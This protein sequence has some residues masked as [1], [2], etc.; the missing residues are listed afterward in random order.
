MSL[1]NLA[2]ARPILTVADTVSGLA[3]ALAEGAFVRGSCESLP[4]RLDNNPA[5][6]FFSAT[7]LFL[8]TG[9]NKI[10]VRRVQQ[11]QRP[12]CAI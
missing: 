8:V 7:L 11:D 10:R 12:T 4:R 1:L 6:I 9:V 2:F 3:R 5:A